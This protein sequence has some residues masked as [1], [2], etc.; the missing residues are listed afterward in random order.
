MGLILDTSIF[1][2][3]ERQRLSLTDMLNRLGSNEELGISV[4]TVAE[5]QHGVRRAREPW[6]LTRRQALFDDALAICKVHTLT[7]QI[8]LR[9]GNLDAE[10][11][12]RG[13]MIDF[14]DLAIGA[15]ALHLDFGVATTDLRH[16]PRIPDLR[17]VQPT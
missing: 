9:T 4:I 5:L 11:C 2:T 15:T 14:A 8:A 1:V 12:M 10:L 3:V 7:T 13:E 6:Q 16:F 17:I